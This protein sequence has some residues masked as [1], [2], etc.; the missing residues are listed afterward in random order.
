MSEAEADVEQAPQQMSE[1]EGR[2][3]AI[4]A[5][6]FAVDSSTV[7]DIPVEQEHFTEILG[8]NSIDALELL[9]TVE[10]RFG[11]EFADEQLN[12]DMLITIRA[13]IDVVDAKRE[14]H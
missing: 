5:E 11:F 4:I 3:R 12:P 7:N 2:V 13:L 8:A 10:E 9:I 14:G 6:V 1:T